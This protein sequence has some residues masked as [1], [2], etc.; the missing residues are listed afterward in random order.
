MDLVREYMLLQERVDELEKRVTQG[1]K[2][3]V[4]QWELITRMSI[5]IAR[6]SGVPEE[7][8]EKEITEANCFLAALG[9]PPLVPPLGQ[10]P[11]QS[12]GDE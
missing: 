1:E 8:L 7:Q 4:A 3:R 12:R 6:S 5:V 11:H 10:S 9:C 2:M